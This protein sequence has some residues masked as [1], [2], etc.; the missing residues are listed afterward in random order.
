MCWQRSAHRV[1]ALL[2]LDLILALI[3]KE[4]VPC[5]AVKEDEIRAVPCFNNDYAAFLVSGSGCMTGVTLFLL[6]CGYN[7][8]VHFKT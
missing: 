5:Q 2:A 6:F 7:R 4:W 8:T 3:C 1:A